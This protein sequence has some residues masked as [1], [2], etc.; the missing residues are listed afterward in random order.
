MVRKSVSVA[1]LFMVSVTC[2]ALDAEESAEYRQWRMRSGQSS[3]VKLCVVDLD[4]TQVRLK[5]EDNGK[6]VDIPIAHL[7]RADREYL[8]A[9]A[10]AG[11]SGGDADVAAGDW[12]QW[13]GPNRDGIC[14]ETGLASEWSAEGPPLAWRVEGLG[15]GMSS[16]AIHGDRIY[17]QGNKDGATQLICRSR[18][19]GAPLWETPIGGG[20]DPNCTPTVDPQANLVFG[21]TH[22]GELLCADAQTGRELWRKSF[23][24][25]FGGKMMSG[26]GYSES[27]L[28]DGDRLIC[29]PGAEDAMIVALDKKTGNLVWKCDMSQ[30]A[31]DGNEGAGY[32]S[33]VVSNAAGVKQYV[34]LIGRGVIGVEAE[35]GRFLWRYR[36]VA[37]GTANVPT[38]IVKG[39]FVFCSSGYGDGGTALLEVGRQGNQVGVR[40]VY[41]K[42]AN[43]LQNHHGGM[44]LI[45]DHVYMGHGHNNGFPACVEFATGRNLWEKQRG[46]GSG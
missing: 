8:I 42:P 32:S 40:E 20:S 37:N 30:E 2:L 21:L 27:P 35:T 10:Q 7:S 26:W 9:Y 23:P 38:P 29:T 12:Y 18:T 17:T 45:G 31:K 43:E 34:Q 28:V 36:R 14:T 11:T 5:R 15:N 19:D 22:A 25:D 13:R 6:I 33:I 41:W 3:S 39:N 4:D 16:V 24:K 1:L 46:A 44:I